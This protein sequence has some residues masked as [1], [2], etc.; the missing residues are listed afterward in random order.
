MESKWLDTLSIE[1]LPTSESNWMLY[2]FLIVFAT[3]LLSYFSRILLNRLEKKLNSTDNLFDDAFVVAM[4]RP[5]RVVLWLLGISYAAEVI[6]QHSESAIFAS[7]PKV[8][9]VLFIMIVGW[10]FLRFAKNVSAAIVAHRQRKGEHVDLTTIDAIT[11]LLKASIVITTGL[12]VMQT[13]GYSINAV[14]TFGG[15]GGMAVG[16]ASKDLLANFF[17]AVMIYLDRPFNIGDW[18]RSPDREIEGTV[19]QIGWRMTT[20]RT[21]DKRPLYIPNSV[22]THIAVENPSRMSQRRIYET[23][24]IR[25][26]DIAHMQSI[27]DAVR[28]MLIAHDDIDDKQTMIVH[29]NAFNASSCDFFVYTFTHTKEWVKFHAI[30]QDLSLI[31][32]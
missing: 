2:V 24:G 28:E 8:R 6:H 26:D 21:F 4:R 18:V 30:K 1:W 14:L 11:N 31:H 12:I 9:E 25:Y 15:I 27:T 19:E 20:I 7:I 29:F 22:F 17:G 5:I 3:L 32:I 16:F 10:T 23:I 13:L